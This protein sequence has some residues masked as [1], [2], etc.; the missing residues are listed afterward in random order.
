MRVDERLGTI[1]DVLAKASPTTLPL[2]K[3]A[4]DHLIRLHPDAVVVPRLGEKSI[5]YGIGV[6]KM[7]EAYCY[8]MPFKDYVNL[9]FYH[10]A[11]IDSDGILQGTGAKLRHAKIASLSDLESPKLKRLILKAI[12]DRNP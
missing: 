8:L 1:D 12:K 11:S 9:G 6:K 10:G 5:A 7:S 4:H 3:A 2:M